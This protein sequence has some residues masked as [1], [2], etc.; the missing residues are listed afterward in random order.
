M[1]D[2]NADFDVLVQETMAITKSIR[3]EPPVPRVIV[4]LN[5]LPTVNLNSE[6]DDIRQR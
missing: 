6:R 5:R 2:W 3:V 4:E 1:T